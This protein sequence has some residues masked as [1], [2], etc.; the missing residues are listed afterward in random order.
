V[1]DLIGIEGCHEGRVAEVTNLGLQVGMVVVFGKY[2]GDEVEVDENN[3]KVE[4]KVLYVG[5]EKDESDVLAV[6][7]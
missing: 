4:Y 3:E 7:E 6:V 5:K 1:P 2:S